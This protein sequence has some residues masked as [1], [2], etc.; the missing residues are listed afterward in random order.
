MRKTDMREQYPKSQP[1]D[2]VVQVPVNDFD[3][4]INGVMES[5]KKLLKSILTTDSHSYQ[6]SHSTV[7]AS[8]ML[9]LPNNETD[10][11]SRDVDRSCG[12]GATRNI[13]DHA[14]PYSSPPPNPTEHVKD[15]VLRTIISEIISET[16][17]NKIANKTPV[18]ESSF[19]GNSSES[20]PTDSH[21]EQKQ[22]YLSKVYEPIN[23]VSESRRL[24]VNTLVG[25]SGLTAI[26][27]FAYG[28][29]VFRIE[30]EPSVKLREKRNIFRLGQLVHL[31]QTIGLCNYQQSQYPL[32]TAGFF[33]SSILGFCFPLYHYSLFRPSKGLDVRSVST[34]STFLLIGSWISFFIPKFK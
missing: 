8:H 25:C 20:W 28:S 11:Y 10:F 21:I 6:S 24:F 12:C 33:S 27:L 32:I 18:K 34:Y 16:N 17:S 31:L 23:L 14:P 13:L 1:I 30:S 29:H 22:I 3:E 2:Q 19:F 4:R 9:K 5:T 7:T 15:S 26:L